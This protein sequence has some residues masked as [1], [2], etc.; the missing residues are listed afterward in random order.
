MKC[1]V[2]TETLWEVKTGQHMTS[3]TAMT[4]VWTLND[5]PTP[6]LMATWVQQVKKLVQ[7]LVASYTRLLIIYFVFNDLHPTH[8]HCNKGQTPMT[9]P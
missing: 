7:Y 5:L 1:Y 8:Y 3:G 2:H 4:S 9:F 6:K